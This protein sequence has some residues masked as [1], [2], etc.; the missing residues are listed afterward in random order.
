MR[1]FTTWIAA[2]TLAGTML[3]P[4]PMFC[5]TST[6]LKTQADGRVAAQLLQQTDARMAEIP[7][8]INNLLA[9]EGWKIY[10]TDKNLSRTYF[11][12]MYR[13]VAGVTR[14]R[15]KKVEFE[16]RSHAINYA[17]AHEIGHAFDAHFGNISYT[18]AWKAIYNEEKN[19]YYQ[20]DASGNC[21]EI[22]SP[23]ELFTS[24]FRDCLISP[25]TCRQTAPIA[26]AFVQTLINQTTENYVKEVRAEQQIKLIAQQSKNF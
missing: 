11:N 13:S 19:T 15:E 26:Y 25:Q 20:H 1:K 14:F 23:V 17:Y 21:Y 3:I 18:D 7:D 2:V 12:G 4:M 10:V 6:R 22:S 5:D 9:E 24:V 16:S 8:C